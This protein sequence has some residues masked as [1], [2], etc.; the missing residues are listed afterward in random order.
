MFTYFL[1]GKHRKQ[2]KTCHECH[3]VFDEV[4]CCG[5]RLSTVLFLKAK[6][7]QSSLQAQQFLLPAR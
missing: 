1:G 4:H 2:M 5:L 6:E 3:D 7:Q